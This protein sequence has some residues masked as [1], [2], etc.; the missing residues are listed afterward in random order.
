MER[1]EFAH[2]LWGMEFYDLGAKKTVSA[3]NRDRLFV[4][5]ST[6]KLVTTGT[7]LRLF[8]RGPSVPNARLSHGAHSARDR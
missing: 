6:T 1:P 3:V 5:G 4:P 2:A 7:A 8:R